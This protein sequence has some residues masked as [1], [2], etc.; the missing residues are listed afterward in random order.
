MI[1][2][3]FWHDR[4]EIQ[5]DRKDRIEL[6]MRSRKCCPFLSVQRGSIRHLWL[7]LPIAFVVGMF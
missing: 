5:N 3:H 7:Y 2:F 4:Y 6:G 1:E